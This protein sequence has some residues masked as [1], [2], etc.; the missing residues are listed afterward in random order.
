MPQVAASAKHVL[1]HNRHVGD[2]PALG[3]RRE[4]AAIMFASSVGRAGSRLDMHSNRVEPHPHPPGPG[5]HCSSLMSRLA[6]SLVWSYPTTSSVGPLWNQSRGMSG[7]LI[8]REPFMRRVRCFPR[9]HLHE[10][11]L[12]NLGLS[13]LGRHS[14]AALCLLS[15]KAHGPFRQRSCNP[16]FRC[17]LHFISKALS[18]SDTCVC[19]RVGCPTMLAIR[20]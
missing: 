9:Q 10:A 2:V 16:P 1:F 3:V 17:L 12:V 5:P 6:T 7:C 14:L 8:R 13:G 19:R 15:N 11:G 18:P 20:G 4:K